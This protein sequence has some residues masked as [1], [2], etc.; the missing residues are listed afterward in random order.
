MQSPQPVKEGGQFLPDRFL[1]S[2]SSLLKL[3]QYM[4]TN[5]TQN[6][7]HQEGEAI[8]RSISTKLGPEYAATYNPERQQW[9]IAI[10]AA[11]IIFGSFRWDG[12]KWVS[13]ANPAIAHNVSRAIGV[14]VDWALERANKR[15]IGSTEAR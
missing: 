3:Y 12:Q 13:N 5:T 2:S 4:I 10:P 14:V 8:A 9:E 11:N 1:L 7:H 15:A 6:D